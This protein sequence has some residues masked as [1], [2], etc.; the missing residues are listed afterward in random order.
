M[1]LRGH[2]HDDALWRVA[3]WRLVVCP[4]RTHIPDTGRHSARRLRMDCLAATPPK[5]IEKLKRELDICQTSI[6]EHKKKIINCEADAE[7][8][9][10]ILMNR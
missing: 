3:N 1:A 9:R 8:I 10:K 2:L 5:E 7:R 4:H 6:I